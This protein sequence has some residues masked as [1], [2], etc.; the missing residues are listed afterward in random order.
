[1]RCVR[2]KTGRGGVR[3]CAK[4]SGGGGRR[5]SVLG[6][7]TAAPALG[8]TTSLR[9]TFGDVRDVAITAGIG[10][11]GAILTD[12]VFDQ[13][14]AN[15]EMLA[16]LTGYRRAL[17]EAATGIALGI[18]VG[19]LAKNPR[20]GAKLAMGP[21]VLAALRIAGE[22]LNAGPF[23]AGGS[24]SDLGMMAIEPYRPELQGAEA[25]GQLG[26]AWQV[27][28]GTPSWMLSPENS[29][30]GVVGGY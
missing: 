3:R 19:K 17:A 7:L 10:A 14:T 1:M 13:L 26:A 2:Y 22:M 28:T 15:V 23:K 9:A 4:F 30:A 11:A 21:V 6:G 5:R 12:I 8:R 20:L 18:A 27:G 24:L 25:P 29:M 16:G